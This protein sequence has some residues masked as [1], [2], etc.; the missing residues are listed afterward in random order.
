MTRLPLEEFH[1]RQA[2]QGKAKRGDLIQSFNST[3]PVYTAG[4]SYLGTVTKIE[5]D[6]MDGVEYVYFNAICRLPGGGKPAQA[7]RNKK[8][9]APQNGTPTATGGETDGIFIID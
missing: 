1:G 6:R 2:K 7:A 5:V 4:S 8:L 9:R 3:D